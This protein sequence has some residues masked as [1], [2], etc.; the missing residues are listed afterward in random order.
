ME[1]ALSEHANTPDVG[2]VRAALKSVDQAKLAL[3]AAAR[4]PVWLA[5]LGTGLLAVV[6]L[7]NWLMEESRSQE[8][9][10][11]LATLAFLGLW[12]LNIYILNRRGL[13]VGVIL[14]SS[15]GRW[16]LLGYSAF[17]LAVF[18]LTG[19]LLEQGQ[20][21]VAWVSTI[22]IC[23]TFVIQVRRFPTGEPIVPSR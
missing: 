11:G 7:G 6:L 13:K 12:G 18:L 1:A 19:W 17:V 8:A 2:D 4:T 20:S 23:A 5:A 10:T 3:V 22:L 16:Y 21:W 9:V 15:A 14:S